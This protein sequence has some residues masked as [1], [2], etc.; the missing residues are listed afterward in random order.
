[1]PDGLLLSDSLI[2]GTP[3]AAGSYT[4]TVWASETGGGTAERQFTIV[5][6]ETV[7]TTASLPTAVVGTAYSQTLAATPSNGG[8][9]TWSVTAGALPAGLTLSEC[10]VI[11]GTPTA[12]GTSA[13]TVTATEEGGGIASK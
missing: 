13:F 12:N 11:S 4:F 1:M 5:V 8:A 10:G 9:I 6:G 3:T 7:I 2:T